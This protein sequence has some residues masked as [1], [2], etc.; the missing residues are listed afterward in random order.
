MVRYHNHPP[1]P[2]SPPART[3]GWDNAKTFKE[4]TGGW[5]YCPGSMLR[6]GVD[7]APHLAASSDPA[8]ALAAVLEC[9]A[10]LQ[11][12]GAVPPELE[13]DC[14]PA[15]GDRAPSQRHKLR[16]ASVWPGGFHVVDDLANCRRRC[17]L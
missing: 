13:A 12:G 8:A 3:Q 2:A 4:N 11:E 14:A 5:G 15:Y 6:E 17:R 1:L 7:I 16:A 10:W 9:Q